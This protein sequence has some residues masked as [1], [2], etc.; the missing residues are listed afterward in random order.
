ME[1]APHSNSL[2]LSLDVGVVRYVV[3]RILT[4]WEVAHNESMDTG[5]Q[6]DKEERE[7]RKEKFRRN[8]EAGKN[9][10]VV[11]FNRP[12]RFLKKRLCNLCRPIHT[13]QAGT[14]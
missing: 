10:V 14:V 2:V 4:E 8:I 9:W 7:V 3:N 12:K 1:L 6:N 5:N 13:A 11:R